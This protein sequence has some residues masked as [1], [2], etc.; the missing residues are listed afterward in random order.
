MLF[1]TEK[2]TFRIEKAISKKS[3]KE[4]VRAVLIINGKEYITFDNNLINNV[5]LDNLLKK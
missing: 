5:L 1:T 3:G 4:Y 2:C